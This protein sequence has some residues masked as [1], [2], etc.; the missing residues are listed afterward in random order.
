[1]RYCEAIQPHEAL[2]SHDSSLF[3][4]RRGSILTEA[5]LIPLAP[6]THLLE[7]ADYHPPDLRSRNRIQ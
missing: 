6:P 5:R 1:M 3:Y 2:R 7:L 4:Y